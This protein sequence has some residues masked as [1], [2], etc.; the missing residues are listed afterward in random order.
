[1]VARVTNL[2]HHRRNNWGIAARNCRLKRKAWLLVVAALLGYLVYQGEELLHSQTR[3]ARAENAYMSLK[4]DV[5]QVA[6]F[7]APRVND[8]DF[9]PKKGQLK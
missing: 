4:L 5:L 8:D 2:P 3:E 7:G 1:M 9:L 6:T